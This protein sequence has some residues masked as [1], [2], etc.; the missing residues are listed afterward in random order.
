MEIHIM[1]KVFIDYSYSLTAS[2]I[3]F[4]LHIHGILANNLTFSLLVIEAEYCD[5]SVFDYEC[6]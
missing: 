4:V 1:R 5:V 6:S 2:I 3:V